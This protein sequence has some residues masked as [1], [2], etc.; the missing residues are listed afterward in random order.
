LSKRIAL[1]AYFISFY[2]CY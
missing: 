2:D 1:T